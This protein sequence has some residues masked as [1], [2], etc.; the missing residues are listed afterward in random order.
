MPLSFFLHA[1]HHLF[2]PLKNKNKKPLNNTT[3]WT[4]K[5]LIFTIRALKSSISIYSSCNKINFCPLQ[6]V[7][8][9][10]A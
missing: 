9:L 10:R 1:D 4:E 8:L 7:M 3:R 6:N 2:D 5:Q